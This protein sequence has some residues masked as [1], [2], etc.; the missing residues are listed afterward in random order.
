M[1]EN[2][3]FQSLNVYCPYVRTVHVLGQDTNFLDLS[4]EGGAHP[5]QHEAKERVQEG[6]HLQDECQ[7]LGMNHGP[8]MRIK[9][10]VLTTCRP[11]GDIEKDSDEEVPRH[12]P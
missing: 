4:W 8:G 1:P 12:S 3:R 10:R 6:D 5:L 7:I 9:G 2:F 11:V